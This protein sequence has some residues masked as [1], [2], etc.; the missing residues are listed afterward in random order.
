M[1]FMVHIYVLKNYLKS[2]WYQEQKQ[3]FA[4]LS[5]IRHTYGKYVAR[6][7]YHFFAKRYNESREAGS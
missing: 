7:S 6:I 2:G 3:L 5:K 4:K 1:C